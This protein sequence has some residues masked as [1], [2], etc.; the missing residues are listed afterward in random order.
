MSGD[1]LAMK[2]ELNASGVASGFQQM[3]QWGHDFSAVETAAIFRP[4]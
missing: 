1:T 3:L 2:A 4:L